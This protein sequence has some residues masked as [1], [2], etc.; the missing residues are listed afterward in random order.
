MRGGKRWVNP[1]SGS[2][3]PATVFF[4]VVV[5]APSIHQTTTTHLKSC[6]NSNSNGLMN[7]RN[8][9]MAGLLLSK[10]GF[11]SVRQMNWHRG[12]CCRVAAQGGREK[13]IQTDGCWWAPQD[14][15]GKTRRLRGG[16]RRRVWC[17][18]RLRPHTDRRQVEILAESK[19][20]ENTVESTSVWEYLHL[21]NCQ[22]K[23][24]GFN[25]PPLFKHMAWQQSQFAEQCL[26]SGLEVQRLLV[27]LRRDY[28]H[29]PVFRKREDCYQL[30]TSIQEFS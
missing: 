29:T 28:S 18:V 12:R 20:K 2:E 1:A 30:V 7:G 25:K 13:G 21:R 24:K 10:A 11:T 5:V 27:S 22:K 15:S 8:K 16:V 23:K 14:T 3:S 9:T 19:K 26:Q 17:G 6:A 4:V